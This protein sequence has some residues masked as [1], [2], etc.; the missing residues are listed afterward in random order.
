MFMDIQDKEIVEENYHNS[1]IWIFLPH[2][3]SL[4]YNGKKV[5]KVLL[6][7]L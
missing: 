5:E 4:N 1:I 7:K 2:S 6:L 3:S